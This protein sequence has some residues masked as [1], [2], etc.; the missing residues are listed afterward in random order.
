MSMPRG[1]AGL[2]VRARASAG[3][4]HLLIRQQRQ[5]AEAVCRER[6]AGQQMS[7]PRGGA[8]LS[9]RAR[10]GAR[11]VSARTRAL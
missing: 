11:G 4:P 7:M 10:A 6:A 8:G 2:S 9:V 5:R 1:G 3:T